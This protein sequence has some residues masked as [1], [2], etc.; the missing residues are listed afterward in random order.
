MPV[1]R[2]S[3]ALCC[4]ADYRQYA[5]FCLLK[6]GTEIFDTAMIT[7]VDRSMTDITFEDVVLL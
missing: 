3:W 1:L 4:V 7:N 6:V 5:V 2:V